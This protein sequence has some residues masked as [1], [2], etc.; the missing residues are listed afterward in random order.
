MIRATQRQTTTFLLQ[1]H[2][3]SGDRATDMV[4]LVKHLIGLAATELDLPG[5]ALRARMIDFQPAALRHQRDQTRRLLQRPAMRSEPYLVATTDFTMLQAA[6]QRQR[7]QHFN[8]AFIQWKIEAAEVEQLSTAI[9][10][11]I[12]KTPMTPAE[13]EAQLLSERVRSLRQTSRGGRVS[14]TTNLALTLDW[15]EAEGQLV[16]GTL[17]PIE[18]EQGQ[19]S[20]YAPLSVWLPD[21]ESEPDLTEAEAQ[22]RLVRAYLAAFGPA[23]EADISF[24]TGFGKSETQRAVSSLARDTTLTMVDG[25]PGALLLL[26]EQAEALKAISPPVDPLADPVISL[27]PADD[28]FV[29]GHKATRARLLADPRHQRQIFTSTDHARPT[30]LIN[31]Q[32]AGTWTRS[33]EKITWELFGS[34]DPALRSRIETE[35]ATMT[36]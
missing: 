7:R 11:L 35:F 17:P 31:G 13:I 20:L 34:V 15:L 4:E 16:K 24:W 8:R 30:I 12:D 5:L 32:I 33:A 2:S 6:T 22:R 36:D 10:T 9:L 23:S 29:R 26:K 21:L 27:L 28:P 19:Q 3:L 1:K 18:D 25:L 14:T